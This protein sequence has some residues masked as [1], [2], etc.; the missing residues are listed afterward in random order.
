MYTVYLG[1]LIL[2]FFA[3]FDSIILIIRGLDFMKFAYGSY[4]LYLIFSISFI[5]L[6]VLQAGSFA[7]M[8]K[9]AAETIPGLM[10]S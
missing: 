4:V 8:V 1:A 5:C 9:Q 6:V 10:D 7:L 2:L 3:A